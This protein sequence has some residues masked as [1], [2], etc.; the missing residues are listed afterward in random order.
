MG[1]ARSGKTQVRRV[2]PV[3]L[4]PNSLRCLQ[5]INLASGSNLRVGT[6]LDSTTSEVELSKEFTLEGR[7]VTLIDT[8][9][10]NDSSEPISNTDILAKIVGFLSTR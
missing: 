9:G 8:P 7:M 3:T 5:F 6:T 2:C 10:F 1:P 4:T